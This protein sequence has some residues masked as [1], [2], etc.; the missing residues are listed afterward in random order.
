MPC[1][2]GGTYDKIEGKSN[3]SNR[4]SGLVPKL[5]FWYK[6]YRSIRKILKYVVRT[7]HDKIG[8][9]E[10]NFGQP[11]TKTEAAHGLCVGC[12]DET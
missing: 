12:L 7:L 5:G 6:R 10:V 3:S 1:P 11:L 4:F 2:R 8:N 9:R